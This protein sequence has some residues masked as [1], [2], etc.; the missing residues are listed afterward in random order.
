M[1]NNFNQLIRKHYNSTRL[2]NSIPHT[3]TNNN[4]TISY[5]TFWRRADTIDRSSYP[6]ST[7]Q[8]GNR[9]R[10]RGGSSHDTRLLQLDVCHPQEG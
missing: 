2:Q 1:A 9:A 7:V 10:L 5:P 8:A 4:N 6:R 3:S